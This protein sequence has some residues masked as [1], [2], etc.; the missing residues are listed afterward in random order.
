M[1]VFLNAAILQFFTVQVSCTE[2]NNIPGSDYGSLPSSSCL[3]DPHFVQIVFPGTTFAWPNGINCY[4]H[5]HHIQKQFLIKRIDRN[6]TRLI[7]YGYNVKANRCSFHGLTKV[8]VLRSISRK[9]KPTRFRVQ[10]LKCFVIKYFTLKNLFSKSGTHSGINL[11]CYIQIR[12]IF[13]SKS[14][15]SP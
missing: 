8:C 14:V 1:V 3:R 2:N 10:D 5:H 12:F 9:Q 15:N 7:V 4:H 6:A 11:V 13:Y